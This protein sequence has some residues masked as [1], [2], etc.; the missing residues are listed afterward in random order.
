MSFKSWDFSFS[1]RW[2][3]I[4]SSG[5]L[6]HLPEDGGGKKYISNVSKRLT[7]CMTQH[8]RKITFMTFNFPVHV[9]YG[10]KLEIIHK[11]SVCVCI[12]IKLRTRICVW[13]SGRGWLV[14]I[15]PMFHLLYLLIKVFS[16]QHFMMADSA[17]NFTSK[18]RVTVLI[19]D[20]GIFKRY[21]WNTLP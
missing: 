14:E 11:E 18:S 1:R 19:I 21:H 8:P 17:S 5:M 12:C 20:T 16:V 2:V 13:V 7:D 6:T 10:I 15:L 9:I 3:R 4:L